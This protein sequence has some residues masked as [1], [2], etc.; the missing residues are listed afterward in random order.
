MVVFS[1]QHICV[2]NRNNSI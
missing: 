2:S 1:F